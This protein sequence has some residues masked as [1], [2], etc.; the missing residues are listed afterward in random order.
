MPK[1]EELTDREL[2]ALRH[3]IRA[4]AR[5]VTRPDGVAPPEPEAPPA[6]ETAPPEEPKAEPRCA[7]ITGTCGPAAET[8]APRRAQ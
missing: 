3:Y 2:D 6:V 4:R 8:V 5:V 1:F 7:R